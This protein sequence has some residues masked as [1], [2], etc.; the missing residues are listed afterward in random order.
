MVNLLAD[1]LNHTKDTDR[2]MLL[3]LLALFWSLKMCPIMALLT[4]T[5]FWGL[6]ASLSPV[7]FLSA[8]LPLVQLRYGSSISVNI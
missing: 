5:L 3:L 6:L 2:F 8:S 1:N 7:W 4:T